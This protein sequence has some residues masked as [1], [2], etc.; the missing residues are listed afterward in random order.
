M[1][2]GQENFVEQTLSSM[3]SELIGRL[4]ES[5][6]EQRLMYHIGRV[7]GASDVNIGVIDEQGNLLSQVG[8]L[9]S[10]T[11]SPQAE[12]IPVTEHTMM[13]LPGGLDNPAVR[14]AQGQYVLRMSAQG[15][16]GVDQILLETPALPV[17]RAMEAYRTVLFMILAAVVGVGALIAELLSR[18]ITQPLIRLGNAGKNLSH[19]IAN[20]KILH[21]PDSRIIEFQQLSNLLGVMS[22]E[23]SNAFKNLK[24]TQN[25]L[26]NEVAQRT[27]A[28]ASSNDLLTSVLDAAV[29]FAIIATDTKGVVRLFNK[30]A[31]NMLGYAA[32]DIIGH[33]TPMI[34]HDGGEV[35][36]RLAEIT[37]IID[38]PL[39]PFDVFT[40][41]TVL[42]KRD[43]Q[44]WVYIT[45]SG[46]RLPIKLMVTSIED[47]QGEITGYLGIAEDI[48]ESKR[49]EQMK[50]EFIATVSHELRTPLTSISGALGMVVAGAL[51]SVS[52][53]VM[54]MVTIAH[55]N[56]QRLTHLI[57]DLLDIEKIAAGK[58]V[59]D[60]Q[61]QPL[62]RL[63]ES[64]IEENQHYRHERQVSLKLDNAYTDLQVRVDGQRLQQVMA[65]LLSNAVKFSPEGGDVNIFV[66]MRGHS[67]IVNVKDDGPGIPDAF[68]SHIF[69]KFAQV[70]ASDS[71][72]KGGTGLGLAITRELVQHMGGDI[73]FVTEE[74]QGSCFWFSLPFHSSEISSEQAGRQGINGTILIV[75]D[76][77]TVVTVLQEILMQAGYR[78]DSAL[79]GKMALEK[80]AGHRY[81][82]ITVDI[83]LP[84]ISGF[85][86]IHSLREQRSNRH[87][88]VLV[89]TG[90]VERGQ[91]A[92]EG[93]LEDIAWLTKPIQSSHLL[94]LL[95]EQIHLTQERLSLLHIED[96]HDLHAVIRTM[97]NDHVDCEHAVSVAMAREC[98]SKRQYDVIILDIGLP[99]GEGWEL[100]EFIREL[101]PNAKVIILSGQS[102]SEA[103]QHR[104][105]AVFLK[106]RISPSQLL[107]AIQQ[108]TQ[109][110]QM[111]DT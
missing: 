96:D 63:L 94:G 92:L 36:H 82:A 103:D 30:G 25:N 10:L 105:E 8:N 17:V 40:H 58:L 102:I 51:G 50:N 16:A 90:S 45:S 43:A 110:I 11:P 42:D 61:W 85:D 80:L 6:A 98:L 89:V 68:K 99:D 5:E 57:N 37:N 78:V 73:G 29:D 66:E 13:W 79:N 65:N 97:L 35:E 95:S 3:G 23:L 91:M 108:R 31:E 75:E 88:P 100:L 101:Q 62:Q 34:F 55:N 20:D 9:S 86:V 27:K 47:Q 7:R 18:L 44:E 84:D 81:D 109:L 22:G 28:L 52:D 12:L 4:D 2:Q 32:G 33:H 76:D 87:T 46:K 26:E 14:F 93:H 104:V 74:G 69:N 106:S 54:R 1:R 38:A 107:A 56:S 59:F 64:A 70:D 24:Y 41:R 19:A 15:I 111:V 67:I 72:A 77:P 53:T 83:N 48:S 39:M 60:M 49:I 71:R 21:L